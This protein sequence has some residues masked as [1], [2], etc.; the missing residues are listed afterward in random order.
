MYADGLLDPGN[1]RVLFLVRAGQASAKTTTWRLLSASRDAREP[2]VVR[3]LELPLGN[4]PFLSCSRGSDPTCVLAVGPDYWG[5]IRSGD[6]ATLQRFHP[7]RG[8]QGEVI[9]LVQDGKMSWVRP[10]VSPS[11]ELV[12][13][14]GGS[15][16]RIVRLSDGAVRRVDYPDVNLLQATFGLDD[17]T[18][19]FTGLLP[20][21][22][23][24]DGQ[25][26][27]ARGKLDGSMEVIRSSTYEWM[28]RPV[29]SDDG[30][31]LAV[32]MRTFNSDVWMIE[33]P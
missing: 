9:R 10:A 21:E 12:A 28:N 1:Q 25:Y 8:P 33:D 24:G 20:N 32:F 16:V 15:S 23:D 5:R 19:Y 30:K 13:I 14:P 6:D 29:V 7:M 17:E 4:R 2:A 11:G 3:D 31:H 22:A 26:F 18:L 27:L